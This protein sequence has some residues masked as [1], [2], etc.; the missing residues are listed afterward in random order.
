MQG[1]VM[2]L[3]TI[4]IRGMHLIVFL[5]TFDAIQAILS[6]IFRNNISST[7]KHGSTFDLP[8]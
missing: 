6:G 1:L 2:L 3:K 4:W 5:L 8:D 7:Q